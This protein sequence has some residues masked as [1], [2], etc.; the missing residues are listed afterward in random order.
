MRSPRV[1]LRC[2]YDSTTSYDL[3][4][5]YDLVIVCTITNFKNRKTVARRHVVRHHTGAVRRPCDNLAVTSRFLYYSLGT[6][7]R[8]AIVGSPQG[9]I[10]SRLLLPLS[11][12]DFTVCDFPCDILDIVDDNG[13]R[14]RCLQFIWA[15]NNFLFWLSSMFRV[16]TVRRS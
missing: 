16:R 15:S 1:A 13:R 6:K 9:V 5:L 12:Y 7:N 3:R 14:R 2:P 11:L 8:T 10:P 4:S